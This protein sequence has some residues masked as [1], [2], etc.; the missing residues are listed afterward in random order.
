MNDFMYVNLTDG[1]TLNLVWH[2]PLAF[3]STVFHVSNNAHCTMHGDLCRRLA[4]T[5]MHRLPLPT[6]NRKDMLLT[7]TRV[8]RVE[9]LDPSAIS[10][11]SA[12]SA[13]TSTASNAGGTAEAKASPPSNLSGRTRRSK[14]GRL[15]GRKAQSPGYG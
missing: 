8:I 9:A 3:T 4:R 15:S 6:C 7:W 12:S 1:D 14:S 10:W 13:F 11:P 2:E 5:W